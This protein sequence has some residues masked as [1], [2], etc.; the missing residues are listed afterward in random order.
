[1]TDLKK[2]FEHAGVEARK[3]KNDPGNERKLQ[4]YALYKQATEGDVEGPRPGL[5]D[6]VGGA[7]HDAWAKVKGMKSEDAMKKYIALVERLKARG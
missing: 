4:L 5:M 2:Q 7:K 6:F 1:M 3:L